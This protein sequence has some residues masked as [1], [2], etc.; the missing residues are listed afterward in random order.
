M[1]SSVLKN[2]VSFVGT[3]NKTEFLQTA[4]LLTGVNMPDHA[5]QFLALCRQI[6]TT[7]SPHVACLYNQDC[8]NLKNLVDNMINQFINNDRIEEVN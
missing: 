4:A 1:F 8:Q 6:K 5:A 3:C 2:F 7:V